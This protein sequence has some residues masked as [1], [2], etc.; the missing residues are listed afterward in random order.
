MKEQRDEEGNL[1]AE[2]PEYSNFILGKDARDIGKALDK[3]PNSRAKARKLWNSWRMGW[4]FMDKYF[5][6]KKAKKQEKV[7]VF[8]DAC[9]SFSKRHLTDEE[10]IDFLDD[11]F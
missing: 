3:N 2:T 11:W 10:I 7:K 1:I 9:N 4:H 8:V 6:N 5:E